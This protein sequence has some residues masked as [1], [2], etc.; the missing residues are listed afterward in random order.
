MEMQSQPCGLAMGRCI[1]ARA[2]VGQA[3]A[4]PGSLGLGGRFPCWL[5]GAVMIVGSTRKETFL[6]SR[7]DLDRVSLGKLDLVVGVVGHG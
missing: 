2:D 4:K 6:N 7:V 3:K 5:F 1:F